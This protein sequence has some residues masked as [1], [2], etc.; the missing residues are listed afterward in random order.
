MLDSTKEIS[1][2]SA[3][4][5]VFVIGGSRVFLGI[6]GLAAFGLGDGFNRHP[7][8]S[9]IA[10]LRVMD[11]QRYSFASSDFQLILLSS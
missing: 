8:D 7:V 1:D 10:R 5:S 11:D 4:A 3:L 6:G 2:G 9:K